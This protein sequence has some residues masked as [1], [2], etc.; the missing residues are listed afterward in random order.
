MKSINEIH[1]EIVIVQDGG[2]RKPEIST[3][4]RD[5]NLELLVKEIHYPIPSGISY[6]MLK[7]VEDA[8]YSH[9][10]VVPGNDQYTSESFARI[11]L[12]SQKY[13]AVLGF[14]QNILAVRPLPKII[15]SKIL[16]Y[17]IKFLFFPKTSWIKDFHGLTLYKVLEINKYL[18]SDAGHGIQISLILPLLY[19]KK[20]IIQTPIFLVDSGSSIRHRLKFP[21]PRDVFRVL[22]CLLKLFVKLQLKKFYTKITRS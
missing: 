8:K 17:V 4:I 11:T 18:T 19:D 12:N 7:G 13:D 14:R 21:K 2:L 5:H 3:Y 6:A 20:S 16:L 9:A 22:D 10:C 15:A 1:F